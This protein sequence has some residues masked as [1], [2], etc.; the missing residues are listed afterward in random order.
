M[1]R[2][3]P[4]LP[5]GAGLGDV[6]AK[7]PGTV[8]PLMDYHDRLL[9]GESP[10]TVAE[11][12]MIAAYVSGLNAC[13]F[14]HDAHKIHA[15]AHGIPL[16][17]FDA[18]LSDVETA[19]VDDRLKPIL[20]YVAKLT[21]SPSRMT[22]ADAQAVYDAGWNERALFDAVMVCATFNMMNRILEGC[23]I[24][25]NPA[26]PEDVDEAAL[27]LRRSDTPYTNFG[28]SLGITG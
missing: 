9:R 15:L 3:L 1:K 11:R 13:N 14:C 28:K 25:E 17:T 5:D 12:E 27:D 8:A 22:E 20:N 23:G 10:L 2:I 19:P 6:F 26:N 24:T 16:S 4:S 7:F 21:K 18:L